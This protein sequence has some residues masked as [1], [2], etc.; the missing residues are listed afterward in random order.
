VTCAAENGASV[1][2]LNAI[3]RWSDAAIASFYT[4]A[5]DRKRL[6][7]EAMSKVLRESETTTSIPLTQAG[8]EGVRAEIE[9]NPRAKNFIGAVESFGTTKHIQSLAQR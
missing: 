4:G 8:G 1:A 6:A 3:F 5:A 9:M 2:Q 7:Q